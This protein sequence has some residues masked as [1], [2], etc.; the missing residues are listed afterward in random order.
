MKRVAIT[1]VGVVSPVGSEI[2][3]FWSALVEGR[4]GIRPI[5]NI[6]TEKINTKL[7]GQVDFDAK[8]HFPPKRMSLIDRFSQFAVVAARSAVGQA[9]L[10]IDEP[11]ALRTATIIGT[12]AGG[13]NTL[14]DSFWQIYHEDQRRTHPFT[15]PRLMANAAA[16]QVSIDLG[17][18][19][20]AFSV[21]SACASGTHAIGLGFQMVRSGMAPVAVTGAS[22]ACLTH[23]TIMAWESLRVMSEDGMCRPF[24][25]N[26]TGLVLGEGAAVLVLEEWERATARGAPILAEMRGFGMSADA[27]DAI[28]PD[29]NGAERAMRAALDDAGLDPTD[30]GY[31][32]AHGTGTVL[33]D[34]DRN[35]GDPGRLR[36]PCQSPR[37]VVEQGGAGARARRRRRL[38]GGGDGADAEARHRSADRQLSGTGSGLRSRRRAQYGP[39]NGGRG[40][41]LQ[42]LCLRRTERGVGPGPRLG[43]SGLTVAT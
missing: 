23:G 11:L 29:R 8:A 17:L 41:D 37:G 32:N 20:P 5:K 4:T 9:G 39:R 1:G 22:E 26:R 6:R 28:A 21:A 25:K 36:Q 15:V 33:N 7:A 3:E 42:F 10:E 19:G 40:G 24:S 27:N 2:E 31:I 43:A 30:I 34:F 38:R 16:S 13:L 35:R 18:K 12:G 14:D